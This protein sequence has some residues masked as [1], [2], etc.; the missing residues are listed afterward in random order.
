MAEKD[1]YRTFIPNPS[2]VLYDMQNAGTIHGELWFKKVPDFL[3]ATLL[4]NGYESYSEP[5]EEA[6][7][8]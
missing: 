6:E 8:D 1:E 5:V 2:E 4:A 7:G 3:K